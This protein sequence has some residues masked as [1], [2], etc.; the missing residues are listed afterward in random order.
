MHI[1]IPKGRKGM[2]VIG[3]KGDQSPAKPTPNP[4]APCALMETSVPNS[5][6]SS[7]PPA[8]LSATTPR[9]FHFS[10]VA[11]CQISIF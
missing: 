8:L 6:E 5:L 1:P 11:F 4:V 2:G 3:P 7:A 10:H 9:W